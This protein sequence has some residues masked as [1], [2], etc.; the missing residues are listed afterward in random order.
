MHYLEWKTPYWKV[1]GMS[2]AALQTNLMRKFLHYDESVRDDVPIGAYTT[3]HIGHADFGPHPYV[4]LLVSSVPGP[5]HN[6]SQTLSALE[7]YKT[8]LNAAADHSV[9]IAS[10]GFATNLHALLADADGASL[11]A[12]KVRRLVT[13]GGWY[14]QSPTPH[15]AAEWNFGGCG[16]TNVCVDFNNFTVPASCHYDSLGPLTFD[17]YSQLWP[18]SVP[19]TFLGGEVG[20]PVLTGG[21][22][23]DGAPASS[24][25]R[26]AYIAYNGPYGNRSSWDPM[27]LLYAVRGNSANWYQMH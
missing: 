10:I 17:L 23:T 19:I 26:A 24:P 5:I 1:G 21:V 22:L 11:V 14:P 6:S 25:V 9:T 4:D 3:G 2:R 27:T 13:M 12:R 7:V 16:P 18:P 8:A 15:A 20:E